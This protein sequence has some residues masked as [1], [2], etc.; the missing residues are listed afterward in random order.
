[1]IKLTGQQERE[2]DLLAMQAGAVDYLVKDQLGVTAL[3]RSMRYALQQQR[4]QDVIRQVNQELE[5]R[6]V[7]R[8]ARVRREVRPARRSVLPGRSCG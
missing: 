5:Q 1:M 6:V 4:H 7:E 8:T 2:L 3:E